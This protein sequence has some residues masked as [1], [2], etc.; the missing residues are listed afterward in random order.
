MDL[1]L[2][3]TFLSV[4]KHKSITQAAEE[5]DLSQPAVSAALKR[6]ESVVGKAMFVREG[7]GIVPTGAAV[8]LAKKIEAPMSVLETV[9]AQ[10]EHLNVYCTEAVL[11][12]VAHIE[13]ITLTET[14]LD[15]MSIID[16]LY[17]QKVDLVI[18]AMSS[19]QHSLI[20]EEFHAE[21]AVC[22][23]RMDHPRIQQQITLEQYFEEQHIALKVRRN[24]LNTLEYLSDKPIA[25]RPIKIETGSIASMLALASRSDYIASSTRS[26]AEEFAIDA[27][28][29]IHEVPLPLTQVKF[30]MLYH[31]RFANDPYHQAKRD[32]IRKAITGN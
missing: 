13:G 27:G 2:F 6:L 29:R 11:F 31:R 18:D 3:T 32:V 10:Q 26:I 28:L 22:L 23:T 21:E 12:K 15:E 20:V 8:A 19:R 25:P 4:Y 7:R 30:N 1:N 9:E 24:D 14:P 17:T 16:D 5:L